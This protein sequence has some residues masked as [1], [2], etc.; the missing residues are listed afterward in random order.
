MAG[1]AK[2]YKRA[3]KRVSM[4]WRTGL[5]EHSPQ[6]MR[7]IFGP[8]AIYLD[9]LLIDHGVFRLIYL[10]K[11][12]LDDDAWRSAQPAP[13]HFTALKREGV[14]TIV[15]LRGERMCGSFWL[16]EERCREL[17]L[18]LINFQ[19]RSRAAPEAELIHRA[20][21]LFERIEYPMLMHCKSGAD[22]AGI[23]SVLYRHFREGVPIEEARNELSL[24]FGHFRQADTGILDAVFDR[25]VADNAIEPMSFMDWVDTRYDPEEIEQSFKANGWATRFVG[26]VLQRE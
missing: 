12:A 18:N 17:G 4:A 22:R 6:W 2:R 13:H 21:A 15:N 3:V 8:T 19:V 16:E 24:R 10:N 1:L 20:K 25:Y 26:T 5:I 11:H 7:R 23:M 9:M 14:K